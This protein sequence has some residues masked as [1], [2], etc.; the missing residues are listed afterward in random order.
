MVS[1]LTEDEGESVML[2]SRKRKNLDNSQRVHKRAKLNTTPASS[3]TESLNEDTLTD[4]RK[5][6]YYILVHIILL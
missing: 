6:T 1:D 5:L 4:D 3:S 2:G